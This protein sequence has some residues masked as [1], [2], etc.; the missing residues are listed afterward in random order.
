MTTGKRRSVSK[1]MGVN[2]AT[3]TVEAINGQWLIRA[4]HW[5][6][7]PVKTIYETTHATAESALEAGM[8]IARTMCIESSPGHTDTCNSVK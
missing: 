1:Q 8:E 2:T 7:A 6:G 4:V 5:D 3:V